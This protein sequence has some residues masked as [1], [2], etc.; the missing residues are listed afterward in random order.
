MTTLKPNEARPGSLDNALDASIVLRYMAPAG[1]TLEDCL[2]PDYWRNVVREAGQ[3]RIANRHAWNRIE[4]LAEDGTWEAELRVLGITIGEAGA[5]GLVTVRLLRRW[6]EASAAARPERDAPEGYT[7]EHIASNGWRAVEPGG[8]VLASK[9]TTKDEA[10]NTAHD[11]A[12]RA[13]AKGGK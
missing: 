7:V 3:Q 1:H 4:V 10:M 6:P 9:L 13:R 8:N 12:R 11:H 2:R 5:G